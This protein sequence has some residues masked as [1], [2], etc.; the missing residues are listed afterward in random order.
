L[1]GAGDLAKAPFFALELRL[2]FPEKFVLL[3]FLSICAGDAITLG[4]R[5]FALLML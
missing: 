1:V 4:L 3:R 5:D 2:G